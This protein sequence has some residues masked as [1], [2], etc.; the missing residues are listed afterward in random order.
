MCFCEA[1]QRACS[2]AGLLMGQGH[3][4]MAI[5]LCMQDCNFEFSAYSCTTA[6]CCYKHIWYQLQCHHAKN[7]HVVSGMTQQCVQAAELSSLVAP[8]GGAG[9]GAGRAMLQQCI[10]AAAAVCTS[11]STGSAML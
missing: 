7:I 6:M 9:P 8:A 5:I 4:I 11:N 10:T 2:P 3:D 1:Q